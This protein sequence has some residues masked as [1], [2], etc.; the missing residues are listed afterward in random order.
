MADPREALKR[1]RG[2]VMPGPFELVGGWVHALPPDRLADLRA[3]LAAGRTPPT[4][5]PSVEDVARVLDDHRPIED[6]RGAIIACGCGLRYGVQHPESEP[7]S[8]HRARAVLALSPGR[9]EAEVRRE[10]LREAAEQLEAHGRFDVPVWTLLRDRADR[11]EGGGD[12][13]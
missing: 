12:R 1:L 5:K 7:H 9:T 6:G 4:V 3:I 13:G 10:A 2:D 11:I 8:I